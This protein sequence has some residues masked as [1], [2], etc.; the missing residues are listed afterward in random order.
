[1]LL[2]NSGIAGG[3]FQSNEEMIHGTRKPP[4]ANKKDPE[5]NIPHHKRGAEIRG[6]E[7]IKGTERWHGRK[8]LIKDSPQGE[9]QF[10]NRCPIKYS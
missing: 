4:P 9:A 6:G 8:S 2:F 7:Y 3:R 10:T 5:E 1:V